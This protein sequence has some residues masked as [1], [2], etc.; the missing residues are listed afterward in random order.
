VEHEGERPISITWR[1]DRPMP[2]ETSQAASLKA[3]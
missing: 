1:L 3:D 2:G